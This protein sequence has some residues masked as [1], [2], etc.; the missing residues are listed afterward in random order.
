MSSIDPRKP[1]WHWKE[2]KRPNEASDTSEEEE[3][4]YYRTSKPYEVKLRLGD[5]EYG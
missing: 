2:P 1:S 4:I 5:I 3:D